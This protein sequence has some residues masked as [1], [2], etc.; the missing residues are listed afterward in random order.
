MIVM[1]NFHI[2]L[3][4]DDNYLSITQLKLNISEKKLMLKGKLLVCT[5]ILLKKF[6][7]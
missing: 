2:I 7:F 1:K 6:E 3:N 5:I 4:C